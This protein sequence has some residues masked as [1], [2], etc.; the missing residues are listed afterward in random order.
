MTDIATPPS[1]P[2]PS[3]TEGSPTLLDR[4]TSLPA[5]IRWMV[6]AGLG[7]LLLTIVQEITGD[8]TVLTDP[9]TSG[10]MLRFAVPILLAGLVIPGGDPVSAEGDDA[11]PLLLVVGEEGEAVQREAHVVATGGGAAGG[12]P[13]RRVHGL[14]AVPAAREG[15]Q[16]VVVRAGAGHVHRGLPET[17][18]N[19]PRV[20]VRTSPG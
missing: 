18:V 19:R 10:A 13:L 12:I 11:V 5:A 16:A 4:Y 7:V 20:R 17:G 6:A 14:G 8:T 1:A 9:G 15:F 3:S 2:A